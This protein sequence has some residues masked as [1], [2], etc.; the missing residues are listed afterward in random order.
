MPGAP[1][2]RMATIDDIGTLVAL[3]AFVQVLHAQAHPELFLEKPD[4]V[5]VSNWF[6]AAIADS[7]QRVW[8]VELNGQ[9]A[10]YLTLRLI[11]RQSSPF[12]LAN[13]YGLID[14]ISV[15]PKARRLGLG[16]ALVEVARQFLC[17]EGITRMRAD[18]WAFN[19]AKPSR[20]FRFQACH[21]DIAFA[22]TRQIEIHLHAQPCIC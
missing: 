4:P 19:E 1:S 12:K 2:I 13:D 5:A 7:S 11:R 6:A 10:G 16:H 15:D 9:G 14:Q 20:D 18:H 22:S 3:N 21:V 8:L 17:D